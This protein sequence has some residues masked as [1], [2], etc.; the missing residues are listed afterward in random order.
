MI[1]SGEDYEEA[2]FEINDRFGGA[3]EPV[4]NLLRTARLRSDLSRLG[5]QELKISGGRIYFSFEADAKIDRGL[6]A[7]LALEGK[8]RYGFDRRGIFFAGT[9]FDGSNWDELIFD[10]NSV[11]GEN[12][13][14]PG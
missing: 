2:L 7:R 5:V 3:P 10:L 14:P 13:I 8:G 12:S 9:D 11:L 1:R 6:I 4:K